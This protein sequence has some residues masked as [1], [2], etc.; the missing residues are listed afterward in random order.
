M[1]SFHAGRLQNSDL[2]EIASLVLRGGVIAFPTDTAYGL[3][4][5]PF[6]DAA[7][8]RIFEIKG[9]SEAKPILLIVSSVAMAKS[10]SKPGTVFYG[11]AERFWPGPLSVIVPAVASL[12][13]RV[14]AGTNTI[15]LRWPVAPFATTLA[16]RI[17]KPLTATSANRGG[18]PATVSAEEVRAQLGDFVDALIDDGVLP[19]RAGSTLLDL[20]VDPPLLLREGPVT[21]ESLDEFFKGRIRRQVA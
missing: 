15:G 10:V 5:D 14:T 12:P 13:S 1:K 8:S 4:A 21:F 17:G 7:V 9:R 3:G 6:N 16:A 18:M 20:T 11:V 2:G 19:S